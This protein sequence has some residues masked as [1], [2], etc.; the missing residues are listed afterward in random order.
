MKIFAQ[1]PH[2]LWLCIKLQLKVYTKNT[3]NSESKVCFGRVGVLCD[4]VVTSLLL[5]MKELVIKVYTHSHSPVRGPRV[6]GPSPALATV[7]FP[8]T[9]WAPRVSRG[10]ASTAKWTE[11]FHCWWA[12]SCMPRVSWTICVT[13]F[14]CKYCA[15]CMIMAQTE[16][17]PIWYEEGIP[18]QK[19]QVLLS[20]R[21]RN[22]ASDTTGR[23][24]KQVTC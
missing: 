15:N 19:V 21:P 8:V 12:S 9:G 4:A 18:Q 2:P 20:K 10:D 17:S 13:A 14:S 16:T 24:L 11:W 22:W 1:K 3:E 23:W 6:H 7:S 5:T